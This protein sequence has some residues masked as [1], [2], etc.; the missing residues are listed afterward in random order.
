MYGLVCLTFTLNSHDDSECKFV[1]YQKLKA[2][3]QSMQQ[4][5]TTCGTDAYAKKMRTTVQP[6]IVPPPGKVAI[7]TRSQCLPTS[8]ITSD[9]AVQL[10]AADTSTPW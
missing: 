2:A 3:V 4:R 8:V 5:A 10:R 9:S 7:P 6:T 1:N